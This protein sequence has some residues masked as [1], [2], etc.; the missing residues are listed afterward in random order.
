MLPQN[1]CVSERV[2]WW[3]REGRIRRGA[4]EGQAG[5]WEGREDARDGQEN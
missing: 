1:R 5:A 4:G 3:I 2:Q